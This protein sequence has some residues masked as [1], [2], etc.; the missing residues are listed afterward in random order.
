MV[1]TGSLPSTI[2]GTLSGLK[3]F[4]DVTLGRAELL[5]KMQP[6]PQPLRLPVLLN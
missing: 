6:V 2:N 5:V 1:D 4:F 3:F